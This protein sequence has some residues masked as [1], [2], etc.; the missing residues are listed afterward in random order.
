MKLEGFAPYRIFL[1]N[2][3]NRVQNSKASLR[4]KES[5]EENETKKKDDNIFCI[6]RSKVIETLVLPLGRAEIALF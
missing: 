1:E 4:N 3:M 5:K 6:R 2:R